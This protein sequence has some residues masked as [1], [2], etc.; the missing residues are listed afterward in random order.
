MNLLE[1][2][3]DQELAEIKEIY[4]SAILFSISCQN[5]GINYDLKIH[6]QD[7]E[8]WIT[9]KPFF[10]I[11]S[12]PIIIDNKLVFDD[13]Q[14]TLKKEICLII[15]LDEKLVIRNMEQFDEYIDSINKN[16]K[17]CKP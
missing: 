9:S 4:Q 15:T 10:E 1:K 14:T 7:G 13:D 6:S 12:F 16:K 17:S 11:E 5:K 8:K 3:S 2:Y